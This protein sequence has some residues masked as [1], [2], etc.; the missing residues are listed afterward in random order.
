MH[1]IVI[2]P[3]PVTTMVLGLLWAASVLH[4]VGSRF[5]GGDASTCSAAYSPCIVH[6]SVMQVLGGDAH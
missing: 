4:L 2:I 1:G 5:D 6:V 3:V